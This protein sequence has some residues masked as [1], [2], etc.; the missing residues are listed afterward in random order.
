MIP[1]WLLFSPEVSRNLLL[2]APSPTQSF[3]GFLFVLG[4]ARMMGKHEEK[5]SE[6]RLNCF[7]Y[8]HIP[9]PSFLESQVRSGP[10]LLVVWK[11][12][13]EE[14]PCPPRSDHCPSGREPGWSRVVSLHHPLSVFD[15][16]LAF[17]SLEPV[18]CGR[19]LGRTGLRDCAEGTISSVISYQVFAP[20]L[21]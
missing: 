7:K 10:C 18:G 3:Q 16:L 21:F 17:C 6:C 15:N 9:I 1:S 4:V 2:L 14:A 5:K 12:V 19:S 13:G 20:G 8:Y 11:W